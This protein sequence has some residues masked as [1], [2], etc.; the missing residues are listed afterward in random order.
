MNS[1][2]LFTY[3]LSLLFLATAC[4]VDN[5]DDASNK[6]KV[7]FSS[8]DYV[9]A[10]EDASDVDITTFYTFNLENIDTNISYDLLG[11]RELFINSNPSTSSGHLSLN[12]FIYSFAKDK[13]G[14]SS[15]P[16][17]YRLTANNQNRMYVDLEMNISRVNLYPARQLC[18]I[19]ENL[20]YFYDEGKDAQSIQIFNP[21]TMRLTGKI[22]LREHIEKFRPD[23]RWLDNTGSNLVRTGTLVLDHLQGKLYVSVVFL[24]EVSFN[25]IPDSEEYFH[26]AVIDIETNQFEKFISY[27]GTNTVGFFVSENKAT[28]T[29]DDGNLYFCSWGWNQTNK[30]TPSQIFR[31][32]NGE[33]D[34]DSDWNINI[35]E[36]FGKNRIAQSMIAYNNKIYIHVSKQPYGYSEDAPGVIEMEY[37]VIDPNNPT[38]ITKLDIPNSDTA[39]RMNVFS[40]VDGKLFISVPNITKGKFNGYYSIDSNGQLT[41]E[42][43]IANKYR[44]TRL[45]RLHN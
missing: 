26:L 21:M 34:F 16:G 38:E 24:E 9:L 11:E 6:P 45:Y 2:N 4:K 30:Q 31:I 15:T 20:G 33:T 23:A 25:L 44:P 43:T 35:A 3:L 41:K 5:I 17:L 8:F 13:K 19:N 42:I 12:Q 36:H 39:S 40:I 27:H 7:D 37:Y 32:K 28:S 22:D 14:F 10:T 29:D 18:I 1:K